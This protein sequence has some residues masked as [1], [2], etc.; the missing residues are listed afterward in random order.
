MTSQGPPR[1]EANPRTWYLRTDDDSYTLHYVFECAAVHHNDVPCR[2]I[3]VKEILEI[4]PPRR[5]V[6]K[7]GLKPVGR[8]KG[9]R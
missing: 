1:W 8:A 9:G 3:A 7:P 6:A 4:L 2:E 5:P